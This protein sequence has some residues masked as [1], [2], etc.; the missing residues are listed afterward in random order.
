M[1]GTRSSKGTSE[2][3]KEGKIWTERRGGSKRPARILQDECVKEL[4]RESKREFAEGVQ[5]HREG[6]GRRG[7]VIREGR[8]LL[9]AQVYSQ[10]L[11]TREEQTWGEAQEADK[12][13]GLRIN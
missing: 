2:R 1:G 7:G 11:S 4:Q 5:G 9:S 8:S 12:H 10:S 6:K 13:V 3:R